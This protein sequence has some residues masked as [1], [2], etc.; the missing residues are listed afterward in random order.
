MTKT[1]FK[2]MGVT[3]GALLAAMMLLPTA[4]SATSTDAAYCQ[5]L[6]QTYERHIDLGSRNRLPQGVE[7]RHGVELCRQGDPSG[8]P[9]IE[10]ALEGSRIP[11]P[12]RG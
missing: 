11:L 5:A 1:M 2:T 7:S 9:A 8:I 3:A 12:S 10:R 6:V 4:G